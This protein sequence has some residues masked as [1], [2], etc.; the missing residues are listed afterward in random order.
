MGE[1][2][3]ESSRPIAQWWRGDFNPDARHGDNFAYASPDY[4]YVRKLV[5]VLQPT[6]EDV[7]Y[8]LGCGKGRILCIVAR[9]PVQKCVGIELLEPLCEVARMN[10]RRLRGRRA[11]VDIVRGDCATADLSD[12]TIYC[13]FNPF[14]RRTME[15]T[16][17]NIRTSLA[18]NPRS[19][20][21]VYYNA[22]YEDLLERCGW[23]ERYHQFS[24]RSGLRVTFW[25]NCRASDTPG[26]PNS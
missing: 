18:R 4:W 5:R 16:L 23:L 6:S 21:I 26:S 19:I 11:R 20:S 25:R 12:G 9:R 24:T 8:D 13:M 14:G 22:V 3:P 1:R 2:H 7:V 17:A 10:A 15:D